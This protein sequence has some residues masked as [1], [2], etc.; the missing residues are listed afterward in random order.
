V[1]REEA[2]LHLGQP[3]VS[4]DATLRPGSGGPYYL[5]IKVDTKS[6]DSGNTKDSPCEL[7]AYLLGTR[8]PAPVLRYESTL[9][10]ELRGAKLYEILNEVAEILHR[11]NGDTSATQVEFFLPEHLI[12]EAVDN[13]LLAFKYDPV[14]IG[15]RN[16]VVIRSLERSKSYLW[17]DNLR[18]RWQYLRETP[19]LRCPRLFRMDNGELSVD[20]LPSAVCFNGDSGHQQ[21]STFRLDSGVVCVALLKSPGLKDRTVGRLLEAGI[22]I[23]LWPRKEIL[24]EEDLFGLFN[25]WIEDKPLNQL[26]TRVWKERE[27]AYTKPDQIGHCLTLLWDDPTRRFPGHDDASQLRGPQQRTER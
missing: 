12:G 6:W 2:A 26:P 8:A 1:W 17:Q 23:M 3:T 9:G 7:D 24:S 4:L 22:P 16:L 10:A 5:L 13:W 21:N 15:V 25:S 18:Q 19:S 20:Q 14:P 11:E 27:S